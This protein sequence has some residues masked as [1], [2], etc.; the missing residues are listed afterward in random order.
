MLRDKELVTFRHTYDS[1]LVRLLWKEPPADFIA[2][3]G[4]EIEARIDAA[5][6]V[7]ARIGE[8]WRVL[9][10]FLQEASPEAVA[11]EFTSL[12]LGPFAPEVNPYESYYLTGNLFKAPLVALRGFLKRLGLE[13]QEQEFAEP[14]DVLAFELE[15]MRWLISKQMAATHPDDVTRWLT[16][17]ATFL[18]EHLLI[19]APTCAQD[20]ARASGAHFYRGVG[21]ILEGFLAVER[22]LFQEL[23]VNE[24]PS[25]EEARQRHGARPTWQGPTFDVS[26]DESEASV[27]PQAG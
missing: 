11:E 22:T 15:V 4:D 19:W 12:F 2:A 6:A 18:K 25:L 9:Q 27:P 16:W 20:M 8:G 17:Q 26:G 24:M 10:R 1:L 14:E 3:L 5:T 23:G 13:K 21:M 7:Q